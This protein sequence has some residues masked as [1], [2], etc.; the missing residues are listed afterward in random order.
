MSENEKVN[1]LNNVLGRF[2]REGQSQLL[3]HCPKCEHHKKK[4][5]INIDKNVFKCWVCGYS[6]RSIY[7]LIKRYGAYSDKKNWSRLTQQV[8]IENFSEKLFGKPEEILDEI[9][10]PQEFVSL[11]NNTLPTTSIY[12]VNYL[13]SRGL[14][15]RDIIR[16]KIGY[17][18]SGKY[19]GRVIFPSFDISG[20]LNY[21]V[22]RSYT[23]NWKR[24]CNP[25][26][27]SDIIFNHLNIDFFKPVT[28]VEGVFDAVKSGL[29]S[30][31]LL[32]STLVESSP[33]LSEIVK[34][35]T[36]VYLALD[37]DAIKKTEKLIE[38][39]LKY[40]IETYFV[41]LRHTKY[42]DVGEMSKEEFEDFKT[43]SKKLSLDDYM[44]D[45]IM[46]I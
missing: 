42:D 5:S 11:A 21:F 15:K 46:N 41:D 43:Q 25:A 28:I 33:L 26:N 24:Y 40:D 4:L 37:P 19:E 20:K 14:N 35:D 18:S 10:L 1:I 45:K 17:C 39:F 8:E 9:L 27:K 32:G 22:A 38:L 23:N 13:K 7:R 2:Y 3:F 30:V 6:G 34:Y 16:W 36:T 12:P 31:P 44:S 29:N